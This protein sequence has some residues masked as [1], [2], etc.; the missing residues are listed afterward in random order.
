MS[1]PRLAILCDYPEEGWPSMDLCAEMLCRQLSAEHSASVRAIRICP[2]FRRRARALPLVGKRKA[3]LNLDRLLN[4]FWDYPRYLR[5]RVGEYDCFH[6]CD[7]SYAQLVHELPRQR[8]GVQCHDLD[9]FRCLLEPHLDPRPRWF[10]LMVQRILAGL[11]KAAIVFYD[12]NSIRC[13]IEK[14]GLIDPAKLIHA[15]LGIAAEFTTEPAEQGMENL[16]LA[17]LDG[18]PFLLHVGS[19]IPRKRIDILLDVFAGVKARYPDLTLVQVGGPWTGAQQEQI[20][21]LGIGEALLQVRGLDRKALAALY[22][23]ALLVLQPSEA[24]GFGLPVVEALS[25]GSIVVASDIPVLR[26]VGGEA[27][28]YCPV[29]DIGAWVDTVCRL[30]EHPT[31]AP[32]RTR[33]LAQAQRYSWSAHARTIA[34]AYEQ[35]VQRA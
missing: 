4:R 33:R 26:E 22:R 21:R 15:P 25:C 2:N 11:Q 34:S 31:A 8:T 13:Q 12:S 32:D 28:L 30:V 7:H 6:L 18:R 23:R 3:A 5:R 14:H 19:C 10:Q 35:L 29:A 20:D 16:P 9:A 17:G 24:E 1:L 27:A